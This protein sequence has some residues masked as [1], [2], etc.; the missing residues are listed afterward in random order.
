M[1]VLIHMTRICQVVRFN[2]SFIFRYYAHNLLKAL[3][4]RAR[5]LEQGKSIIKKMLC[6]LCEHV[7]RCGMARTPTYSRQ[8]IF[9]IK[10]SFLG[11]A[12]PSKN[13][14]ARQINYWETALPF[15]LHVSRCS[16]YAY[17]FICQLESELRRNNLL[18]NCTA[19][20]C[21]WSSIN[22]VAFY[23]HSSIALI[24]FL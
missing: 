3:S 11:N 15:C 6:L 16:Q 4:L 1:F 23:F 2:S 24:R 7:S 5:I 13:I 22:F 12:S 18:V 14:R 21:S 20:W 17:L 10:S 8:I 9:H 19:R